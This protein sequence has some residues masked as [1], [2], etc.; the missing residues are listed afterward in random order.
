MYCASPV[1][2]RFALEKATCNLR[3]RHTSVHVFWW[4]EN[5]CHACSLSIFKRNLRKTQTL[6][7][8]L[9]LWWFIPKGVGSTEAWRS[10]SVGPW[11]CKWLHALL[12]YANLLRN[13]SSFISCQ[14]IRVW[15]PSFMLPLL[16]NDAFI[17][18]TRG[19]SFDS[20]VFLTGNVYFQGT[21]LS[22]AHARSHYFEKAQVP[23][24]VIAPGDKNNAAFLTNSCRAW[25]WITSRRPLRHH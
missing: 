19:K 5:W 3:A 17:T 24:M 1:D 21:Q 20:H 22:V 14:R 6:L 9:E 10:I 4:M 11:F 23:T 13:V 15:A 16:W 7:I 2:V 18:E 8:T 25:N 12:L